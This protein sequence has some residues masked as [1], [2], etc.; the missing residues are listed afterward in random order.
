MRKNNTQKFIE[1]FNYWAG[2]FGISQDLEFTKD[3][4]IDCSSAVMLEDPV[5]VIYN[6]KVL[7]QSIEAVVISTV[8]HE[9]AHLI[10]N[11]PYCTEEEIIFSE[12]QAEKWALNKMKEYYPKQYKENNE[13]MKKRMKSSY[14]KK[15]NQVHWTA[16]KQI[17]EYGLVTN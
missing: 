17:T 2:R 6:S 8:F 12:Y 3:N 4:R 15:K 10:L 1:L 7:G 13:H 14:W 9:I 16:W 11:L 5:R